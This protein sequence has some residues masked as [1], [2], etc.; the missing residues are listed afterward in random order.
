M[1]LWAGEAA[2]GVTGPRPA[3]AIARELAEEAEQVVRR[4]RDPNRPTG[5]ELGNG[6]ATSLP[7]R[8][9]LQRVPGTGFKRGWDVLS[10]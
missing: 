1:S 6:A 3:A 4:R 5:G 9:F 2:G 10:A 8:T 7:S